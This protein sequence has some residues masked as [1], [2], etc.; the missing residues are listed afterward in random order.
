[1]DRTELLSHV[2][3]TLLRPDAT[4]TEIQ[5]LC[6]EA[7]KYHTASVCV[8]PSYVS[9]CAHYLH[10]RIPVCTVIGFP[11]GYNTTNA[12]A[13]EAAEAADNGA[14]E[15]DVVINLGWVKDQQWG[16]V[17]NEIQTVK[18]ACPGKVVKVIIETCLLTEEEKLRLCK[19]VTL[20]KLDYIKTSTGFSSGG[21]TREDV[22]LLVKNVGGNVKVKASGGI[23]TLEDA[24]AFLALGADRL[25]ASK[26]VKLIMEEE[27]Q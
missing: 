13:F 11:N 2:D 16:L 24:E 12:K 17:M 4:W 7:L 27:K 22:E 9:R 23:A 26:V 21:A 18:R 25:G 6:D 8:P 14:D 1:M 20:G 15:L 5:Q 10:G 19:T 3:H